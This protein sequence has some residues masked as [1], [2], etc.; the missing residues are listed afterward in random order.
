MMPSRIITIAAL[1]TAVGAAMVLVVVK[2]HEIGHCDTR[3][4]EVRNLSGRTLNTL[5]EGIVADP[6]FL[7]TEFFKLAATPACTSARPSKISAILPF[8]RIRTVEA[9]TLCNQSA[10]LQCQ[11][12]YGFP[13]TAYCGG[14]CGGVQSTLNY[15]IAYHDPLNGDPAR[16]IHNTGN[17]PCTDPS[18]GCESATCDSPIPPPPPECDPNDLF[19]RCPTGETC[20]SSTYTCVAYQCPAN[21]AYCD[22]S[23]AGGGICFNGANCVSPGCCQAQQCQLGNCGSCPFY[24]QGPCDANG[25]C[26]WTQTSGGGGG[27][28]EGCD[29]CESECLGDGCCADEDP[30]MI[31]LDGGGYDLTNLQNGV[32]FDFFGNAKPLH[33]SWT[34]AGSKVAFLVLDRNSNGRVDNAGEMFSNVSWPPPGDMKQLGFD[35]LAAFDQKQAGGNNDGVINAK[36]SVFGKLR[37]W[38]DLNHNAVSEPGELF[39]MQQMGVVSISVKY[40]PSHW[41]DV[42]GNQFRYRAR[43]VRSLNDKGQAAGTGEWA[44]DVILL[45]PHV[46]KN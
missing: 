26:T 2:R 7:P 28:C 1:C 35:A 12:T 44:Y 16:G 13:G 22:S 33:T 3:R 9:Q 15:G 27:G 5:F 39:T 23:P 10:D 37:L 21:Q 24:A 19:L 18:C 38:I 11:G 4:V 46:R 34:S 43:M 14:G 31:D 25:C 32:V 36:D 6:R 40:E 45:Q 20:D 30:V 41:V 8:L 42:Y 29:Y 17:A